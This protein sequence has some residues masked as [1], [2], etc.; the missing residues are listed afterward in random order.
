MIE[1]MHNR[2]PAILKPEA[3]ERWIEPG[4][5]HPDELDELLGPYPAEEMTAYPVSRFVNNPRNDSPACIA[6]E[7][8]EN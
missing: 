2:M 7:V 5:R 6:P 4:E 1:Q 3:Y 8:G